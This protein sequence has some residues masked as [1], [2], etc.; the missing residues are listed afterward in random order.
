MEDFGKS[1]TLTND[2][3]YW[4]INNIDITSQIKKQ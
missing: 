1:L 3:D 4:K 2:L